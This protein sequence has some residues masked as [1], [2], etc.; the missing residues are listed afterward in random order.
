[1]MTKHVIAKQI[2]F[3]QFFPI[4][5]MV[6]RESQKSTSTIILGQREYTSTT[7]LPAPH[8][9]AADPLDLVWLSNRTRGT[10]SPGPLPAVADPPKILCG[11]HPSSHVAA[12]CAAA[13]L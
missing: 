7:P 6:K 11:S 13:S 4:K 9:A 1:M 10:P 3:S 2:I 5:R 12:L 8:R